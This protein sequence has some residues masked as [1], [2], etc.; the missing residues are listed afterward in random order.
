[1]ALETTLMG[2]FDWLKKPVVVR[3]D[4]LPPESSELLA[5]GVAL[6][7]PELLL[8]EWRWLVAPRFEPVLCTALGDLFLQGPGGVVFWLDVGNG[9][10]LTAA[11]DAE[12]FDD[13]AKDSHHFER[14]FQPEKVRAAQKRSR[15]LS[16]GECYSYEKAPRLGG[17]AE[18]L[19]PCAAIDHFTKHGRAFNPAHISR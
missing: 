11:R 1:M 16:P 3:G 19:A 17:R 14:W 5:Q 6:E 4:G 12:Q 15:K 9:A 7:T 13:L 2:L 18:N 10:F 8:S